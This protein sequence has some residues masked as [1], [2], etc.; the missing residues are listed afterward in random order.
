MNM[1]CKGLLF[2]MLYVVLIGFG[3]TVDA[4]AAAK[5]TCHPKFKNVIQ[6]Y[7]VTF[8]EFASE[9]DASETLTSCSWDFGDGNTM[10]GDTAVHTYSSVGDYK[11]IFTITT[12]G[13]C[14]SSV[15]K[16]IHVSGI[17]VC[18]ASFNWDNNSGNL[19]SV[20]FVNNSWPG[21]GFISCSWDFGDG[22]SSNDFEPSHTYSQNG[23]YTVTLTTTDLTTG[24]QKT[25]SQTLYLYDC[26]GNHA[27]LMATFDTASKTI[28][29][30][31]KYYDASNID[32]TSRCRG[33]WDFGDGMNANFST[34]TTSYQYSSSL[35]DTVIWAGLFLLDSTTKCYSD[36]LFSVIIGNPVC[37]AKAYFNFTSNDYLTWHFESAS[38]NVD[39]KTIFTWDFG[40]G[41]TASGANATHTY[42]AYNT[43]EGYLAISS[44]RCIDTL[45]FSVEALNYA[46]PCY[47][48]FYDTVAANPHD[49][50]FINTAS[51]SSRTFY[52]WDF[53]DGSGVSHD[54]NPLHTYN[55]A[56]TYTVYFTFYDTTTSCHI[57]FI[58][59]DIIVFDYLTH[60]ISGKIYAGNDHSQFAKVWAIQYDSTAGTLTAVDSVSLDSSN[61]EYRFILPEGKYLIKAALEPNSLKYADFLPTY[62]TRILRWDS[63]TTIDLNRN[64]HHINIELIHGQNPGGAG[65]IGG[66]VS[67]GAN[68]TD[69]VGD[70][71]PN[72]Q[73][74]LYDGNHKPIGFSYSDA[75]GLFTFSNIGNGN[76]YVVADVLGKPSNELMVTL[77]SRAPSTDQLHVNVNSKNVEITLGSNGV[78]QVDLLS[79]GLYPNPSRG[80]VQINGD[81]NRLKTITLFTMDGHQ[82]WNETVNNENLRNSFD[83]SWVS[84]GLYLIIL[85]GIDGSASRIKWLKH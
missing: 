57:G 45:H 46:G 3:L 21:K 18:D 66:L 75:K 44:L 56:G 50:Q 6:A 33:L 61:F 63:A 25:V 34:T 22:N 83:L 32:I 38:E 51:T 65:F 52:E 24:C 84:S 69:A 36:K 43:Y 41:T 11:I 8:F 70:P 76:Y 71:I 82:V 23:N 42:S 4:S 60:V 72:T 13:G 37:R 26:S 15:D 12:S 73:V 85:E 39:D 67:Q 80:Q 35:N 1:K 59:T 5:S 2:Q 49:I 77:T 19:L 40:D 48:T 10:T 28:Y 9:I 53:G 7:Q 68:K 14:T 30:D 58:F 78:G 74:I 81:V 27:E 31:G 64:Y 29:L 17:A 79:F 54:E 16:I 55:Q 47:A 20:H 62:Y